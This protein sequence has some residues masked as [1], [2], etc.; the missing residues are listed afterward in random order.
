MIHVLDANG[1]SLDPFI[2]DL[3]GRTP[4]HH[5]A[6]T[7]RDGAT[8]GQKEIYESMKQRVTRMMKKKV[9]NFSLF[10]TMLYF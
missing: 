1:V 3:D 2:V 9:R 6:L 7:W 5:L 10:W 4:L 8:N